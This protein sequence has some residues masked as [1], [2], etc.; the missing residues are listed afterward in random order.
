M[1]YI[2]KDGGYYLKTAAKGSLG[3]EAEITRYFGEKGLAAEVLEYLS[4]D[5]DWLLTARVP[6]EDCTNAM[7][8]ADPKRLCDLL[9]SVLR[10]LHETDHAGCPVPDRMTE[11]FSLVDAN[12]RRGVFDASFL[13]SHLTHLSAHEAWRL[14]DENRY[15]FKADTLLH[16][17]YCLPN[18]MLD[19]WR[20]SRFVDVDHGGVGDRHVDLYWGV[21]TLQF[22]LKTHAYG[23]R[24]LDAYG[25]DVLE[26]DLLDVI[27]AAEAFG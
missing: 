22:N 15:R 23:A 3:R 10:E 26:P 24:F 11:Y 18:I 9:A 19:G 17:D 21:W 4:E 2:E 20:F 7:Y 1:Y 14:V 13:P 16:G 25:R 6:G 5:R 12:Y 8:L 27:G